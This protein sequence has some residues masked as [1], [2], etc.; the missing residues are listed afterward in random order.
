MKIKG[1]FSWRSRHAQLS[2]VW[3][4]TPHQVFV[5]ISRQSNYV[6]AI[7]YP[8]IRFGTNIKALLDLH[9]IHALYSPQNRIF[10][11]LLGSLLLGISVP[12]IRRND[13]EIKPWIP[14]IEVWLLRCEVS[15]SYTTHIISPRLGACRSELL[16]SRN[17]DLRTSKGK[18]FWARCTDTR[19]KPQD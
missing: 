17:R 16:S 19:H 7:R 13:A 5:P 4:L 8:G 18:K 14:M 2:W 9:T 10:S 12:G 3:G 1:P 15:S 11:S 6:E